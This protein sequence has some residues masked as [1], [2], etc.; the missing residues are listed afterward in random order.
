M[1]GKRKSNIGKKTKKRSNPT[2]LQ[3]LPSLEMGG[4]GVERGAVDVAIAVA[5]SGARSLVVSHGGDMVRELERAKVTHFQLPLHSKNPWTIL[6]NIG[7]LEKIIR[8]N[9]VDIV[10]ARSRAPAWS[11]FY[12]A[13]R[14]GAHFVTTFHGT[15]TG[16]DNFL[17]KYYNSIQ[18]RGERVIVISRFIGKHIRSIYGVEENRIRLVHRGIDL[19]RFDP[20]KVSAE[21]LVQLAKKWRLPD[22]MSVVMLPGRITRW[23]GQTIMI[24]ALAQLGRHDIR[25]LLVGADQGRA[26]YRR[27]LE[28]LLQR[29]G[30]ADIVHVMEHC[31]DMPAAYML[32]DV[33][34]SA[35]TD[36]EAFGRVVAEAQAMGRPVIASDHG[37]V[38]E[39]VHSE[40]TGWLF[41]PGD[42]E[43]LA[44]VLRRVLDLS[45]VEREVLTKTAADYVHKNFSKQKMCDRTLGV[46]NDVMASRRTKKR[47][48]I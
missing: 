8:E 16:V 48:P 7:R 3:V 27:E 44:G 45:P 43:A 11:A 1:T 21:R 35:S 5:E 41:P 18:T 26:G 33:V 19:D 39:M 29:F 6:V 38:G 36:P 37:G 28:T 20:A 22:G 23:K 47:V 34:V 9:K 40:K 10:H 12:A 30:L 13:K 2:V 4:G 32:S 14:V 42:A 46:Y 31:T 24:N 17:K 25:C 15:Y